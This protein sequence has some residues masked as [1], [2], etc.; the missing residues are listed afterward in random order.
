MESVGEVTVVRRADLDAS[1]S[2]TPGLLRLAAVSEKTVSSRW[3]WMGYSMLAPGL[4]TGVHHHGDSETALFILS[5]HGRWWI[6]EGLNEPREAGPSDFVF[7]P[8]NVVHYEENCSSTEVVQMI[9]ARSTQE[10]VVVNLDDG[11]SHELIG[12]GLTFDQLH[13]RAIVELAALEQKSS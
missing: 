4:V 1:T 2:Q 11:P 3:I 12:V 5:G 9:V 13:Q 8:P 6:G 7:I 10:A